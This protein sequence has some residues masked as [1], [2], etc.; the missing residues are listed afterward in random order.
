MASLQGYFADGVNTDINLI[1]SE[2]LRQRNLQKGF[3]ALYG[4]ML[5]VFWHLYE[6]DP[7]FY[8]F[9]LTRDL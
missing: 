6:D 7:S 5:K 3:P 9:I 8:K 1:Y 4:E 2:I